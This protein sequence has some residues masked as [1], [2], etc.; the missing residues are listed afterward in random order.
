MSEHNQ[1][2][3]EPQSSAQQEPEF[4]D[5]QIFLYE[6]R[7]RGE[8]AERTELVCQAES[9]SKLYEE[10]EA[11]S[12]VF[13]R[14]IQN[15]AEHH[16][17]IRRAR[18]DGN[19]FFRAFA[20]AWFE[21]LLLNSSQDAIPN[22]IRNVETHPALLVSAGFQAVAYEDFY[23]VVLAQLN[24]LPSIQSTPEAVDILLAGFQSSEVSD[25][26]V[27]HLR[28]VTSA[29]IRT[30]AEEYEPFLESIGTMEQFCSREV[31]CMGRESDMIHIIA[32]TRVF[33]QPLTVAYLDGSM[34][35]VM[36]H[37]FKPEDANGFPSSGAPMLKLI[38]RPGH[39][40][41][42]YEKRG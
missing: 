33:A 38:Y 18:G 14:K 10:Y 7:I 26:I 20:F 4:T 30:H 8:A 27:M 12:E 11:G 29:F 23:D 19:C 9:I 41:I 3:S 32:L 17:R 25:A 2:N 16:D 5:E 39:Y 36:F 24:N 28:F 6:Q 37:E 31:E 35:E 1:A 15:L 34:D 13:Q 21:S 40:D 42:L 22:A